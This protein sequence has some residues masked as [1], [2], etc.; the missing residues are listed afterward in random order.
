MSGGCWSGVDSGR[1]ES[2]ACSGTAC[3]VPSKRCAADGSSAVVVVGG[4]TV[5]LAVCIAVA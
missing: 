5:W 2:A 1:A 3:A 4:A